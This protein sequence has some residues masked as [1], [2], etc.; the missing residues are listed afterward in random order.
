MKKFLNIFKELK[1]T[2]KLHTLGYWL[3]VKA[4]TLVLCIVLLTSFTIHNNCRH[5]EPINTLEDMIEWMQSDIETGKVDPIVGELY[6]DN[7]NEA[8]KQLR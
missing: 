7:M 5:I 1:R 8:I 4:S 2:N 6:I 3:T